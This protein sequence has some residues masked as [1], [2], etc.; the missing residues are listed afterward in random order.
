MEG[1]AHAVQALELE[2]L[3]IA[4][5]LDDGRHRQRIVAGELRVKARA[6]HYRSPSPADIYRPL[7]RNSVGMEFGYGRDLSALVSGM[8]KA[9][10]APAAAGGGRA[11][12]S[13]VDGKTVVGRI[14]DTPA[15]HVDGMVTLAEPGFR[16]WS[17]TP[18]EERAAALDRLADLLEADRDVLMSLLAREGGKT[19]A[20]GIA[21]VR[22]A[23]DFCRYYAGEAR[24]LFREEV[25]PGPTGE[26]DVLRRRGRGVFVCISPWNFPLAIFLGQVTAALA[27]GN[28][29]LAKPAEQTPLIAGHAFALLHRAGVPED[30]A[31]LVPGDRKVGAALVAHPRIAGVVF[32]GSTEVAFAINRALAAKSG[33]IVPLIAETGGI[34]AMIV[35]ATALPE[36]VSDDVIASAFRSAGQ[37]CSALR[38]LYLQEDIA[39][40]MIDMIA[41]AAA[42]LKLGDPADPSTDVGPIIDAEARANLQSHIAAMRKSATTRFVGQ[43]P[44]GPLAG[45]WFFPPHIIELHDAKQLDREVFGPIL[46]VVR[47]R[48]DELDQVL[49]AIAA[50]GYGLTLGIHTRIDE[51]A[52]RIADRLNVGNVYVNRNII[53]AV[54]GTQPFGGSGLS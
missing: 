5:H 45:G 22:E 7:R 2:A 18:A 14:A 36:Q 11:V 3:D 9:G 12:V 28:A 31:K 51:T 16:R 27:A 24:L 37:R 8:A 34:N 54:V 17:A 53:G 33:P 43:V 32:T 49:E 25:M 40:R 4:G 52:R 19:L 46:H 47:W 50:T 1:I 29:V 35:D 39:D 44:T 23:V 10:A 30:V 41:G 26:R 42:E 13:P 15:A 6:R 38:I 20:D 48:A 21:E